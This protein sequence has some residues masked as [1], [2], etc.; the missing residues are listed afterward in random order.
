VEVLR[1]AHIPRKSDYCIEDIYRD[2]PQEIT[3][4]LEGMYQV[5]DVSAFEA[6]LEALPPPA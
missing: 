1:I 5:P 6:R 3:R 4:G 2:L